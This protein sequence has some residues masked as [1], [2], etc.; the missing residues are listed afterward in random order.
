[1]L[2]RA[3]LHVHTT[4]SDGK[5]SPWEVL[6]VAREK[7][8]NVVAITDHDTFAG[9]VAAYRYRDRALDLPLVLIGVEVRCIEGDILVY[10]EKEVDVP[11]R[12]RDLIEKAHAENC[13]V[14]PAHPYDITRLGIGDLI[15][16]I[17]DWDAIEVWNA[18]A[19]KRA[20]L[21]ALKAAQM[22]GKPGLA[23]SD[24]HVPEEIGSAYTYVEVSDLSP[25]SVLE[26]I[27][28]GRV[29]PIFHSRPFNT[30]LK[31]A[32]WSVERVVRDFTKRI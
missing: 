14:V 19:T 20:N 2:I 3:D 23:S 29:K 11:R 25:A 9:S 6:Y 5:A 4:Y 26:A 17:R 30:V 22:L 12:V 32:L 7:G 8:L 18:S 1:L 31:R 10:C 16:E 13:L 15:L 24:A 28:R 27:K 21:K